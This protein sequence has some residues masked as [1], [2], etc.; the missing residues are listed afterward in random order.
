MPVEVVVVDIIIQL[1]F[2]GEAVLVEV[3]VQLLVLIH[4]II[5]MV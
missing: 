5:L 3:A 1:V 2:L 4:L